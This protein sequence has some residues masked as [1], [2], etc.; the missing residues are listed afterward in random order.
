MELNACGVR[1]R[2]RLSKQAPPLPRDRRQRRR[3]SRI[4]QTCSG[5]RRLPRRLGG[6][7][8]LHILRTRTRERAV[9][10]QRFESAPVFDPHIE[11]FLVSIQPQKDITIT[12]METTS[13]LHFGALGARGF[14][15][16]SPIASGC[17]REPKASGGVSLRAHMLGTQVSKQNKSKQ[18]KAKQSRA[19]LAGYLLRASLIC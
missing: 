1:F 12:R 5:G 14:M 17:L 6:A 19:K 16:L 4:A 15:A 13:F 10:P 3:S 7:H 18:S 2:F 9:D 11:P 8:N